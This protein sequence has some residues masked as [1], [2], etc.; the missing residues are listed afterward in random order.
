MSHTTTTSPA[1][2]ARIPW[3][4]AGRWVATFAAFPLGS[5]AARLVVGSVDSPASAV[6][7][8]AL[9]G[10]VLGAAQAWALG[11]RRPPALGWVMATAAGFA[12]GLALGASVV[13][14]ATDGRSLVVQ[15]AFTGA[16]VGMAQTAVLVAAGHRALALLWPLLLTGAWA[17]GWAI[18]TAVGVEVGQRFTVFGSSGAIVVSALTLVLPLALHRHGRQARS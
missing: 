1:V 11:T 16:G 7:G 6:A 5:V 15:G 9:N 17:L 8:G 3:G 10:L 4:A 14:Y 2:T 12:T 13:G 18:T